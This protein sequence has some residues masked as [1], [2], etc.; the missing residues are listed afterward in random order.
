MGIMNSMEEASQ[1]AGFFAAHAVWCV[2][3][4]ETLVPIYAFIDAQRAR[5]M[6]RLAHE[7]LED[8]VALGKQRLERPDP[9]IAAHVL[10]FDGRIPWQGEKLDA[11]IVEWRSL[12]AGAAK[13]V[14]ALPYTPASKSGLLKRGKPF[15]VHKP[16]LLDVSDQWRERTPELFEPFFEGVGQHEKGSAV[17]SQYLDESK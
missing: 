9:G 15:A 3:A 2:S 11:L 13:V 17:W 6:H 7:R 10:I 14:V 1:L 5:Q 12:D 8:G 4:G 16:K